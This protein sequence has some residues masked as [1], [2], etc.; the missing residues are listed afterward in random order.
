MI[1]NI[2]FQAFQNLTNWF[3]IL[4]DND[5]SFNDNKCN[6]LP[7]MVKIQNANNSNEVSKQEFYCDFYHKLDYK[8]CNGHICDLTK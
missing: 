3:F 4:D 6:M 5:E 8:S 1:R 7:K 2:N